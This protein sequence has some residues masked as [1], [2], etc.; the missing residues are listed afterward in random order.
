MMAYMDSGLKNSTPFLAKRQDLVIFNK[1]ENLPNNRFSPA[2]DRVKIKE[3]EKGE[4]KK[5]S[6]TK[7]TVIPIVI[8]VLSTIPKGL[9]RKLEGLEI[10]GAVETIKN[11]VLLRSARILRRALET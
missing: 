2:D 3:N 5:L 1:K 7:M 8:D 11:K 6:N 10:R 4:Q 9:I